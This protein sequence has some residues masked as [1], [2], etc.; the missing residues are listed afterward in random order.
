M[1]ERVDDEPPGLAVGI[2]G[3]SRSELV[4]G[5][6]ARGR[7]RGDGHRPPPA[8]GRVPRT[9]GGDRMTAAAVDA[10]PSSTSRRAASRTYVAVRASSCLIPIIITVALKANPPG[11]PGDGGFLLFLG[12]Q[13]GLL[14]PAVALRFTSEFLLGHR[15]RALRGRGD[16]GRGHVGEPA[17]PADAADPARPAVRVEARSWRRCADGSR[18][19]WS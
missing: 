9:G 16:R 15:R 2:N 18:C 17:L 19:C 12:S 4:V 10:A 5:A 7:R 11:P 14:I 1:V 13:S 3:G 8:R 6:G